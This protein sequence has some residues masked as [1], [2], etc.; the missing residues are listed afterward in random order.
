MAKSAY[1]FFRF[2]SI[3]LFL[4]PVVFG[5][6]LEIKSKHL[7]VLLTMF[8]ARLRRF[9]GINSQISKFQM[10]YVNKIFLPRNEK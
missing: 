3:K 6:M 9:Q 1:V 10:L 7:K 2:C 4:L 8:I 5:N